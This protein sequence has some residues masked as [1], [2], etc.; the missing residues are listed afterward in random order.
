MTNDGL[1]GPLATR[2]QWADRRLRL[3]ILTG[4]IAPGTRVRPGD[5]A[6]EWNVSATPLR[7]AIHRLAG[8]G[9]IVESPHRGAT[10]APLDRGDMLE[11]YELRLLVEPRALAKSLDAS[12]ASHREEM[13]HDHEVWLAADSSPD[14]DPLTREEAHQRFHRSLLSRCP[15]QRML[16]QIDAY[17]EHSARYRLAAGSVKPG[18]P[19]GR[20]DHQRLLELCLAGDTE[21]AVDAL[22]EHLM[23]TVNAVLER[24]GLQSE[25][26]AG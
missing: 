5:L 24:E 22:R 3:A 1:L 14:T 21:A 8:D 7:E 19:H 10:V 2:A 4:E 11:L 12:D 26:P 20:E 18:D 6:R 15:S 17:S 9:L 23:F 25:A 16:A 13:R